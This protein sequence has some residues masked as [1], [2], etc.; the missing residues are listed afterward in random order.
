MSQQPLQATANRSINR[1]NPTSK[2]IGNNILKALKDANPLKS[3]YSTSRNLSS[4]KNGIYQNLAPMT[5]I[6]DS[7][8]I[9]K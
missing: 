1:Y 5:L 8:I 4:G 3:S 7:F 2:A 6:A 9:A